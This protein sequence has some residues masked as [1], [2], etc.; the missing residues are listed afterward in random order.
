MADATDSK[1]VIRKDVWVQVPPRAPGDIYNHSDGST[2]FAASLDAN[3]RSH[4][5]V[6]R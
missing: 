5:R 1:S 3:F 2:T 4:S 6:A